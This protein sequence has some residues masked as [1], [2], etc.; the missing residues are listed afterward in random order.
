VAQ[1]GVSLFFQIAAALIPV[2]IFASG[3]NS[4]FKPGRVIRAA[5]KD[6]RRLV[7]GAVLAIAVV[8]IVAEFFA[9]S[10][11]VAG[12][13]LVSP[14][15][16]AVVANALALAATL[17]A[18]VFVAPWLLAFGMSGRTLGWAAAFLV[19]PATLLGVTALSRAA[20]TAAERAND[21]RIFCLR[22]FAA[23]HRRQ[24]LE[25]EDRADRHAAEVESLNAQINRLSKNPMAN[26][27]RVKTLE[28]RLRR[29]TD[30][31]KRDLEYQ[32]LLLELI[33]P[34]APDEEDIDE[35]LERYL[36]GSGC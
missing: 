6:E 1:Q 24:L 33:Q 21:A 11:A 28:Q 23:E 22:S 34:P 31:Y 20:Y 4:A 3:L 7:I 36:V 29:A 26:R 18:I 9:I 17:V 30:D 14:F 19:L 13:P 27:A 10:E 25:A 16:L 5:K 12:T 8:A 2:L 32:G 35:Y 15:R